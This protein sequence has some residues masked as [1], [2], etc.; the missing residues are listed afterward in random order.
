[1]SIPKNL[2][3]L[4]T[5]FEKAYGLGISLKFYFTGCHVTKSHQV[6]VKHQVT[7]NGNC[8]WYWPTN[9]VELLTVLGQ[10]PEGKNL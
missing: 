6:T 4:K 7:G 8:H 9:L 10:L 5:N 3:A 2:R 1:M